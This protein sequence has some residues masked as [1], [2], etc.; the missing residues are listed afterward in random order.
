MRWSLLAFF[1]ASAA[2]K[3][4]TDVTTSDLQPQIV[5]A[6]GPTNGV[7]T[8]D[9]TTAGGNCP[10][11]SSV[12]F[13]LPKDQFVWKAYV[14]FHGGGSDNGAD[15]GYMLGETFGNDAPALVV[16][17]PASIPP[18]IIRRGALFTYTVRL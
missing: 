7:V 9:P 14:R 16:T 8:C 17:I 2:C 3:D 11:P 13:R 1:V 6:Q 18:T 15:R 5:T 4:G 10:L 12:T